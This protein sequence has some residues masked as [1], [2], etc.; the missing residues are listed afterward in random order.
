MRRDLK[1]TDIQQPTKVLKG[2]KADSLEKSP[3]KICLPV[4][5]TLRG[6]FNDAY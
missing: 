5:P 4:T 6:P 3:Q 2:V 1:I